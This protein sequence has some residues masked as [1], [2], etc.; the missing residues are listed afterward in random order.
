MAAGD[1]AAG[2]AAKASADNPPEKPS[3]EV[4]ERGFQRLVRKADMCVMLGIS[5]RAFQDMVDAGCPVVDRGK[6]GKPMIVDV[7]A[8]LAWKGERDRR[9]E[10]PQMT[11]SANAALDA[12]RR[13]AEAQAE[14]REFELAKMRGETIT[15]AEVVP[16][17]REELGAVRTRLLQVAG[18]VAP[19]INAGMTAKEIE[20]MIDEEIRE[21]LTEL[22]VDQVELKRVA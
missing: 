3:V 4:P 8:V 18:R 13:N 5:P 14:L 2:A 16:I 22:T 6:A 19:N 11:Q 17:L 12:R 9:G 1:R 15:V 21:A 20:E 10:N 7:Q